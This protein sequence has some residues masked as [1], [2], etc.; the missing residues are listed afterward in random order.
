M[1]KGSQLKRKIVCLIAVCAVIL[2]AL[3]PAFPGGRVYADDQEYFLVPVNAPGCN[4]EVNSDVSKLRLWA[5]GVGHDRMWK[6]TENG[7]YVYFTDTTSGEVIEIPFRDVSN[8]R[9]LWVNKYKGTDE[10][11][12]KLEKADDDSYYIRSKLN[13]GFAMDNYGA[14]SDNGAQINVHE[15]NKGDNQRF[16][17]LTKE[18]AEEASK[19]I[20]GFGADEGF[21]IVPQHAGG[22]ALDV[23]TSDKTKVQLHKTHRGENQTWKLI[24]NGE[25][26]SILN[27]M[28]NKVL[29]VS[30]G[31]TDNGTVLT[32][33]AYDGSDKQFWKLDPAGDGSYFIRSKLNDKKAVDVKS[34]G[35]GNGNAIILQELNK[36][37]NQRF[38]FV[39]STTPEPMNEWGATRHDVNGSNWD[40]WDGTWDNSWYYANPNS[41]AYE[42]KTAR[43][44]A[45]LAQLV[46]DGV[47]DFEGRTIVLMRD[48]NLA[49]IEWRRIGLPGHS[50]AGSFN[51]G[52]HSIIGLS[53]TTSSKQDGFFGDVNGGCITNF[54]IKGSVQGDWEIGG[55]CGVMHAGHIVNVYSEVSLIKTTDDFEGGIC[56][57]LGIDGFID[58]CTQNAR[59]N[60]GDQDPYRG[61][62][63]GANHGVISHCVNKSS[64]DCNWDYVGGITGKCV[65]GLIEYCA[66]Y[67]QVSGGGDT[68]W[69]GGIAGLITGGIIFGCYNDGYIYS[70]NDD[71]IGGIAGQRKDSG[72]VFCCIN[73][74]TVSGDDY[75][76]GITGDGWCRYCLNAGTV[77][78]DDETGAISGSASQLQWCRALS[79]TNS[80]LMGDSDYS[81]SGGEWISAENIIS[82]KCTW[83]LN[84]RGNGLN[85]DE[86]N[87]WFYKGIRRDSVFFQTLGSDPYPTFSGQKVTSKSGKYTNGSDGFMVEIECDKE[88]GTV[89]GG[90]VYQSGKVVLKAVPADGCIF[91]HFEVS[92]TKVVIGSGLFGKKYPS[93]EIKKYTEEEFT[94]TDNIDK[95]YRVKAVF[96]VFDDTPDDLKQT[97]KIE[98]ECVDET[99]GWNSTTTPCYLIDSAGEKHLW[100]IPTSNIDGD[101]RKTSHT[102]DIG[103]AV[104]VAL[105]VYPDFGGGFTFHDL[106]L[107]ARMWIN[108][109][110]TAIESDKVMINSYPFISSKYG[111]DYMN[112]TFGDNGNSKIGILAS[113]GTF[114]EKGSYTKCSDAWDAAQKLGSG[115]CVRMTSA[116][117][118]D[119]ELTLGSDKKITLDLNGYP[120]IRTIKKASKNGELIKVDTG[121]TLNIIDSRPDS[122][123]CSAFTGGSIQG[124]RSSNTGG[125]IDVHGTLDMKGGA[126]YNGGTTE[127]GGAIRVMGGAVSLKDTLISNCW[128]NQARV[129][130][131]NGGGIAIMNKATVR[132]E[133]C[134][135]RACLAH[136]MGGGIYMKNSET[137]LTLV[138]T[139]ILNCKAN[140]EEGGAI[141]QDNGKVTWLG[142]SASSC[143]APSDDGGAIW[144]NNGELY[145]EDVSFT[146]N[147]CENLGGA[148]L[149]NTDDPT[150]FVNCE[151]RGNT[152]DEHGGAIYLDDN[153]LY[154]E[155]CT[156]IA[157]ACKEKG[158]AIYLN[159]TGSIDMCG[160]MVIKDNDGTGTMDNLVMERGAWIY[161]QG[162]DAG[163]EVHLRSEKDGEQALAAEGDKTSEYQLRNYL[164]ADAPGGLKLTD[165]KSVSSRLSA[166]ALSGGKIAL[167]VGGVLIVMAGA[168]VFIMA[169][170]KRK[171]GRAS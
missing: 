145:C 57:H 117:L 163:S 14:T 52:G 54:A 77:Y 104:P 64:V 133:N 42:I 118:T 110:G 96:K 150:Y 61:G 144:Q 109:A 45:G 65:E 82:G 136:E 72:A 89:T 153:H 143:S 75:V 94:L 66:N 130:D 71:E 166:S 132:L 101:G 16:R 19:S 69:A 6:V 88:Y 146:G 156:V 83:D 3:L 31:K 13:D 81:G 90:G 95:S 134:D 62:I 126:L 5:R 46:R 161:D 137:E 21:S 131:N 32:T 158:G 114:T 50:F 111:N 25:Y 4:V 147:S 107:K 119:S 139:N 55:V 11:L 169:D 115:A 68:Q 105:E 164:V 43:Q 74:G 128:A 35:V 47:T 38:R 60:S 17:L 165:E 102:F 160:K 59:V 154:M 127:D 76:G 78:G 53:I 142:G 40:V 113:D 98:I 148:V 99:D 36:G 22:S 41:S 58:H 84:A 135:I 87:Q 18:Q 124:G 100:E 86:A 103:T 85:F 29:E 129:V 73:T 112:I 151:F 97:V 24:K 44:L 10:Q 106:G 26:F 140:D 27:F 30:G 15:F 155:N 7:D 121:A 2:S 79:G 157:N 91:D 159:D 116:W 138:N 56:G 9:Q 63:T 67:G 108:G 51:G 20:D 34:R 123:T 33:A 162:L 1:K 93:A 170:R 152:S 149:I 23:S 8:G 70:S 12:W 49:G 80:S 39:H 125:L 92:S 167:I 171:G 28:N 37:K 141:H 168:Y 120:M 122:R 48:I